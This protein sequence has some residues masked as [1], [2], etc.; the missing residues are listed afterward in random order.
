MRV[1]DLVPGDRVG[2]PEMEETWVF[3][4]VI[5]PHPI[6]GQTFNLVLWAGDDRETS[7]D[8]LSPVQDVGDVVS[9]PEEREANL[10]LVLLGQKPGADRRGP[11]YT[12]P[13]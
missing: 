6:F 4:G 5:W 3:V 11:P 8:A 9:Q 2:R 12:E 10:R 13:R 1:S 7:W